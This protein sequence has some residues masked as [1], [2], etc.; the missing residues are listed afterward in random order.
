MA[1]GIENSP[2]HATISSAPPQGD[3]KA[4]DYLHTFF[5]CLILDNPIANLVESITMFEENYYGDGESSHK[6]SSSSVFYATDEESSQG[7]ENSSSSDDTLKNTGTDDDSIEI[8]FRHYGTGFQDDDEDSIDMAAMNPDKQ[9]PVIPASTRN[10]PLFD[11]DFD[12]DLDSALGETRNDSYISSSDSEGRLGDEIG[13]SYDDEVDSLPID[14]ALDLQKRK[15]DANAIE[16]R[17][18]DD[19]TQEPEI[20]ESFGFSEQDQREG[21]EIITAPQEPEPDVSVVFADADD[22]DDYGSDQNSLSDDSSMGSTK[23]TL[24]AQSNG[25]DIIYL[26]F[27]APCFPLKAHADDD[28]KSE[29]WE[30][31]EKVL[32]KKMT[33]TTA[34]DEAGDNAIDDDSE[35]SDTSRL[36]NTLL[37]DEEYSEPSKI[38]PGIKTPPVPIDTELGLPGD[39]EHTAMGDK[40][41]VLHGNENPLDP[42]IF[43]T[44][45]ELPENKQPLDSLDQELVLPGNEQ[46]LDPIDAE[47]APHGIRPEIDPVDDTE[48]VMDV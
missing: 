14:E 27:G 41:Q 24:E 11:E 36:L 1:M 40:D 22:S 10:R 38:V 15:S 47:L 44:K 5:S 34:S 13:I 29:I 33:D 19:E 17:A 32:E 26:S 42:V 45:M 30:D 39:K 12:R 21:E 46:V 3:G 9:F 18:E 8:E 6:V 31:P 16:A 4:M 28:E 43:R 48:L 35:T 7:T 23:Y 37:S 25:W 2:A 20:G